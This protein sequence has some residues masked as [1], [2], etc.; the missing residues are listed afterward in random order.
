MGKSK[1]REE[2]REVRSE[3]E[4]KRDNPHPLSFGH[5]PLPA[6]AHKVR[7]KARGWE[8]L[9][10]AGGHG[11]DSL[12]RSTAKR[13]WG[14]GGLGEGEGSRVMHIGPILG[15]GHERKPDFGHD[16]TYIGPILGKGHERKPDFGHGVMHIGPI[17]GKGYEHKPDFGYLRVWGGF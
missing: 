9:T 16:V 14:E 2:K 17:L 1:G 8:T 6:G 10:I 4:R 12:P 13:P 11:G 3:V 5:P 15:K 7:C